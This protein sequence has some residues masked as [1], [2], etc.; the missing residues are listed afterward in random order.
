MDFVFAVP[1]H[2]LFWL[3]SFK[4]I[5]PTPQVKK[6]LQFLNHPSNLQPGKPSA[7]SLGNIKWARLRMNSL[8]HPA[9]GTL[10]SGGFPA[11]ILANTTGTPGAHERSPAYQLRVDYNLQSRKYLFVVKFSLPPTLF[12]SAPFRGTKFPLPTIFSFHSSLW[13]RFS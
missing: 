7:K 6:L 8:T 11:F 1:W 4:L 9:P 2:L 3:I 13:F 5:H 10:P 12:S